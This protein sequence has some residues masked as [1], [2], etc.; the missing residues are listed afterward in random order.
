M[1]AFFLIILILA[2]GGAFLAGGFFFLVAKSAIH[3]IE[4]LILFLISAVCFGGFVIGA[5]VGDLKDHFV[6]KDRKT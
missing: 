3:E 2:S 6:K 5:A 4:G 1:I